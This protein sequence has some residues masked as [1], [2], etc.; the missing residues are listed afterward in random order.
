MT[1]EMFCVGDCTVVC[2]DNIETLRLLDENSVD[3]CV[4]DP[5]YGIGFMGK[6]WDTFAPEHGNKRGAAEN[7]EG[8]SLN[9]NLKGR[10]RA[11]ASSPSAVEYDR[12][13]AGQ[14]G[15]QSWTEQWAREVLRVLKPGG[16]L[17]VCGAPRSQ[18][19]MICGVEDAG[20]EIR[21]CLMWVFGQGF[22]KSHNL[23]GRW[24]GWGTALKPAWEPILVA[25]KP[26]VGTVAENV[27]AHGTGA[28]NIA[29]CRIGTD[30]TRGKSSKSALGVMND[31]S[32]K[33]REVI[34]GPACGRWPAN[35][36][37]D[38]SDEV[39]ECFPAAAGQLADVSNTAP[40][41]KT[42]SVYGAM[43][44][45]GEPSADSANEGEVGFKMKPGARRLDSGSSARFFYCAK[46]SKRDRND[47]CHNLPDSAMAMSNQAKA[48]LARGNLYG[49]KQLGVNNVTMT[50]NNHPTVK[51]IAL[52]QWLVR[53]VTPPGGIVLDPFFGS[54]STGKACVLEGFRCV[55]IER[56]PDYVAISL[57]RI[58]HVVSAVERV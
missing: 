30:D 4:T 52:M 39:V 43:A 54:G 15:F 18:H 11:P 41:S 47:G 50:K 3:S 56:E 57:A 19:R 13:L 48:E 5:P 8:A 6:K 21:D 26:L 24:K 1:G 9:P 14:R 45:G 35:L 58:A 31:D 42:S 37:H 27:A 44:R 40:S 2:G 51:P 17:L 34:A 36:V 38:G 16:H 46:A 33:A 55:G 29:G 10:K 25:R 53:L 32:W 7:S 23:H 12:S 20:F 49:G 22:P 28:I